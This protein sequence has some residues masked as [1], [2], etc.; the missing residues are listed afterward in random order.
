MAGS[1]PG[2]PIFLTWEELRQVQPL[3]CQLLFLLDCCHAGLAVEYERQ[4]S[5]PSSAAAVSILAACEAGQLSYEREGWGVFSRLVVQGLTS[6]DTSP[7]DGWV[8]LQELA[9]YVRTQAP[10]NQTP[11]FWS[12]VPE[13]AESLPLSLAVAPWLA[14]PE[15]RFGPPDSAR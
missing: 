15:T 4:R 10:A 3:P 1:R 14:P 2:A 11:V 9:D 6:A 7:R 5:A 8:V 13:Q 12:S